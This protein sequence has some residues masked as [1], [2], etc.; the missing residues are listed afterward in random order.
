MKKVSKLFLKEHFEVLNPE[1]M[2]LIL[3][4]SVYRCC[5]SS[6]DETNYCY[7]YNASNWKQAVS[8]MVNICYNEMGGCFEQKN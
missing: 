6:G 1:E 7:D 2:K 4:G 8:Y 3:G 5:C